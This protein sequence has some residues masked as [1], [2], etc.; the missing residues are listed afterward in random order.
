MFVLALNGGTPQRLLDGFVVA[1]RPV[2]APDGRALV[3]LAARELATGQPSDLDL[4]RVPLEGGEPVKTRLLDR[5]EWRGAFEREEADVGT[6]SASGLVLARGGSLWSVPLNPTT[7]TPGTAQRL[8]LGAGAVREPTGS[9]T[10]QVVFRQGTSD[11]VVERLSLDETNGRASAERLYSD[12]NRL[13]RRVS[14]SSDGHVIVFERDGPPV[15]IWMKDLRTGA[16][17]LVHRTESAGALNPTIAPDG[18]RLIF[19][20]DTGGR[21]QLAGEGYVADVKGGVP[22]KVCDGCLLWGFLSDSRRAVATLEG[23]DLQLIDVLSGATTTVLSA[24]AD[25]INRPSFSPD[26]RWLAF[27][28]QTGDVGKTFLI[29]ATGGSLDSAAIIDEPTTTGRPAGWSPDSRV[30][31]L[32][33]DT[34]GFRCLWAQRVDPAT[35]RPVG[36][37]TVARHLHD[38]VGVSTSLRQRDHRTGVSLRSGQRQ[39]QPVAVDAGD[40]QVIASR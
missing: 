31:Y 30:L 19:G 35:G 13:T 21:G 14:T 40:R 39:I 18:T 3:V 25:S 38:L 1:Q 33:L 17:Q 28:R 22:R 23:R 27:R 20:R 7:A 15:E 8:L 16:Q 12:G 11:R 24:T 32:L 6:W 10:G 9:A 5:P 37:P 4:W 29:R 34:D 36:T 2:W 26:G